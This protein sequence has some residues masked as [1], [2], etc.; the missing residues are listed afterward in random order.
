MNLLH[1]AK[2]SSS[3]SACKQT[4]QQRVSLHTSSNT[5]YR[6]LKGHLKAFI[7]VDE[8]ITNLF[9]SVLVSDEHSKLE[10]F[11]RLQRLALLLL[12]P[13]I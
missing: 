11:L 5:L 1:C 7:H 6:F 10:R 4:S 3:Q 2:H 9:C 8:S 12:I 13:S